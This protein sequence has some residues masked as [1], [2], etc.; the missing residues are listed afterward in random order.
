[1]SGLLTVE[2]DILDL[3]NRMIPFKSSFNVNGED[4]REDEGGRPTNEE[5]GKED[6]DET[7]RAKNKSSTVIEG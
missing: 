1:M 4:L 6:A 3:T 7:A 2:N 5:A